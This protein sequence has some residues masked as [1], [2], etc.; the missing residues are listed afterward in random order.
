MRRHTPT[1]HDLQCIVVA[2]FVSYRREDSAGW[3]G[4]I[5]DALEGHFGDHQLF[6]DVTDI[7]LGED[8]RDVVRRRLSTV[9]TVIV[10][11]GPQWLT[12]ENANGDRR[13]DD[14]RDV[15]RLEVAAALQS[16][17]TVIPVLVDGAS[18]P[19]PDEL[20][21]ELSLLS[22]TNA[23]EIDPAGFSDDMQ[24]LVRAADPDASLRRR[25]SNI[26]PKRRRTGNTLAVI[27][28]LMVLAGMVSFFVGGLVIETEGTGMPIG[29]AI[30]FGLFLAG[31]ITAVIGSAVA[32]HQ[33]QSHSP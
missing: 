26:S 23:L 17:A 32:G 4:R 31:A 2:I 29:V 3:A 21:A 6:M 8:F 30:G 19:G 27:G 24:R 13:I 11:I 25:S 28:G 16:P 7:S 22:F 20:P 1:A 5:H 14:P 12:V 9:E 10:V 18:M 33:G 15:V